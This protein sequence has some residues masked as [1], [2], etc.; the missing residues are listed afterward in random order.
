MYVL[1]TF[2][3]TH[4]TFYPTPGRSKPG[5]NGNE[6]VLFIPQSFKTGASPDTVYCH[7]KMTL[8]IE[9]VFSLCSDVVGIFY[10]HSSLDPTSPRQSGCG[11]NGNEADWAGLNRD[12]R[13]RRMVCSMR[14]SSLNWDL[15]WK[16]NLRAESRHHTHDNVKKEKQNYLYKITTRDIKSGDDGL[17]T[18]VFSKAYE[19]QSCHVINW[20][21]EILM[22]FNNDNNDR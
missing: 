7:T 16:Q 11:S 5:S 15:S 21:Y 1:C 17:A 20:Q 10:G 14:V 3:S 4:R 2:Y 19:S 12:A 6:R 18:F 8:V 22:M 9:E 13:P